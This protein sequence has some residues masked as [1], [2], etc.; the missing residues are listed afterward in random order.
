MHLPVGVDDVLARLPSG[1]WSRPPRRWSP[2][3]RGAATWLLEEYELDPTRVHVAHPGVDPAPVADGRGRGADLLCVGAVTPARA[4]TCCW[5]PWPTLAD[6]PWHCTCVG[7][8]SVDPDFVATCVLKTA[9]RPGSATG[10]CSTG[11]GPATRS[12]RRTPSADLLVLPSRAET[13]GMVVT[14]ALARGL[15]VVATDV[16]GVREA[17]GARRPTATGAGILVPHDDVGRAGARAAALAVRRGPPRLAARR[18]ALERRA[19]LAGWSVT[20]D[21][22]ARVVREVAGMRSAGGAGLVGCGDPR[23]WSSGR[24]AATRSST[25]LR[26]LDAPVLLLGPAL[27]AVTTVALRVA[28]APRRPRAGRGDPRRA[29]PWRPATARSS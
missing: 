10:S 4:R 22:V 2:R 7:P 6:L 5:L 15:P 19:H 16:G 3:A 17:L 14:E 8:D 27:A 24:S 20:A 28:L 13:Y 23:A 1:R 25:G 11:R 18:G 21:R 9:P 26:P 29:P 12:R